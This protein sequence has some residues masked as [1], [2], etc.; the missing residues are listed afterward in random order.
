M[1][2]INVGGLLSLLFPRVVP[3]YVIGILAA[4]QLQIDIIYYLLYRSMV[5]HTADSVVFENG[6]LQVRRLGHEV[7]IPASCISGIRGK[8][9][10]NPE[11]ITIDLTQP[12]VIGSS[13]AFI[14][15]AR[16]PSTEDHPMIATLRQLIAQPRLT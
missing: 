11:T 13:V 7:S 12:T 5:S 9:G 14:P 16:F 3:L 4:M 2:A 1:I 6:A 8:F 15:P 10:L